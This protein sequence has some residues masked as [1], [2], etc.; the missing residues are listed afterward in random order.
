MINPQKG[1]EGDTDNVIS[2]KRVREY[3]SLLGEQEEKGY[4]EAVKVVLIM[5]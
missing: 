2:K 1:G 3:C 5:A 4:T